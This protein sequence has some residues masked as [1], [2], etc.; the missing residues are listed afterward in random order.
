MSEYKNNRG[1]M[2]ATEAYTQVAGGPGPSVSPFSSTAFT[3]HWEGTSEA[4]LVVGLGPPSTVMTDHA[5]RA[6]HKSHW[7][8]PPHAP[9]SARLALLECSS[10]RPWGRGGVRV[11][12]ALLTLSRFPLST[13]CSKSSSCP[14]NDFK[15]LSTKAVIAFQTHG[16]PKTQNVGAHTSA[17]P[18]RAGF[19]SLTLQMPPETAQ[20]TK[21]QLPSSQAFL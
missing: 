10:A 21:S 5:D 9:S 17:L 6:E 16:S 12:A 11:L 1:A 14:R 4:L 8:L 20:F 7:R 13:L 2:T 3:G 18:S 15:Q 19:G